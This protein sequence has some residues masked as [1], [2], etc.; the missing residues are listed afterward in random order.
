MVSK[1][2]CKDGRRPRTIT[3]GMFTE[4]WLCG[5]RYTV[6]ALLPSFPLSLQKPLKA[7]DSIPFLQARKLRVQ[8]SSSHAR[9]TQTEPGPAQLQNLCFSTGIC[10]LQFA[11]FATR[12]VT[13]QLKIEVESISVAFLWL[14][15][16]DLLKNTLSPN[17]PENASKYKRGIFLGRF[18]RRN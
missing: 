9:P 11:P 1:I 13:G 4:N 2:L 15:R 18:M 7:G 6:V 16:I 5:S 14:F 3:K 12:I 17:S 8:G 10:L